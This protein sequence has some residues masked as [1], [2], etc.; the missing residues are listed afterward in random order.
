M[1]VSAQPIGRLL[2]ILTKNRL[3]AP[4][5]VIADR[6]GEPTLRL[7]LA[8]SAKALQKQA[9]TCFWHLSTQR[10]PAALSPG[11]ALPGLPDFLMRSDTDIKSMK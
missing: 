9:A 7:M 1:G 5:H 4:F 6:A 11:E 10:L 8:G 3:A 2:P